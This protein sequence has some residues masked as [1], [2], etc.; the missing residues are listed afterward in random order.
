MQQAIGRSPSGRG[1]E[2]PANSREL[3]R[4]GSLSNMSNPLSRTNVANTSMP[5]AVK[6]GKKN[7]R[8]G[9]F[10]L[11]VSHAQAESFVSSRSER[12][13]SSI[14]G[15]FF[16]RTVWG[17]VRLFCYF[18]FGALQS[19]F[20]LGQEKSFP[21]RSGFPGPESPTSSSLRTPPRDPNPVIWIRILKVAKIKVLD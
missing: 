18:I 16:F 12:S 7:Q 17:C 9:A 6:S 10:S 13:S 20:A 5:S 1:G 21:G 11:P 4:Q 2:Q 8:F 14:L 3:S 19:S 15:W